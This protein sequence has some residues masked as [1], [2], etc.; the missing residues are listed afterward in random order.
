MSLGFM[1]FM[2]CFHAFFLLP[3]QKTWSGLSP[4][5]NPGLIWDSGVSVFL[6]WSDPK[7]QF[8]RT[9]VRPKVCVLRIQTHRSLKYAPNWSTGVT[10]K[11]GWS[12]LIRMSTY[13]MHAWMSRQSAD[14]TQVSKSKLIKFWFPVIDEG[15]R[16][17]KMIVYFFIKPLKAVMS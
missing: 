6:Y 8:Y 1:D 13:Y 17:R 11:A 12:G 10:R 9:L 2:L 14:L 4:T 3:S 5:R 15:G 16:N 7:F